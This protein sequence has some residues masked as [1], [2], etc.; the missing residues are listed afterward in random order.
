MLWGHTVQPRSTFASRTCANGPVFSA[1]HLHAAVESHVEITLD[2]ECGMR[3]ACTDLSRFFSRSFSSRA[4][5]F[6][7]RFRAFS[8]SRCALRSRRGSCRSAIASGPRLSGV[9]C[10]PVGLLLPLL[11]EEGDERRRQDRFGRRLLRRVELLLRRRLLL[12]LGL[13]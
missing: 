1:L 3:A 10:S 5:S 8:L 13:E 7:C 9:G 2:T 4:L 12:W 6:F 11:A